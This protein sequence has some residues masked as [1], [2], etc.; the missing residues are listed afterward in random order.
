MAAYPA[1]VTSKFVPNA[2]EIEDPVLKDLRK[3]MRGRIVAPRDADYE[4]MITDGVFNKLQTNRPSALLQVVGTS[5]GKIGSLWQV[6]E[7]SPG[8][9][10]HLFLSLSLECSEVPGP[11]GNRIHRLWRQTHHA[12]LQDRR[13]LYRHEAHEVLHGG[14]GKDGCSRS[15]RLQARRL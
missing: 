9:S 12:L 8:C 14:Q 7:L 1:V 6:L 15:R 4:F 10:S 3:R 11:K 2:V 5:D 13:S